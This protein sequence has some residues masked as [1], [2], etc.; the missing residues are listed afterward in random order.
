[1]LSGMGSLPA[2]RLTELRRGVVPY[3]VLSLLASEECYAFD[4]VR[5][6]AELDGL[7]TS[8]GTVYPLLGR[9]ADSGLVS[10]TWRADEGPRPRKYYAL[11]ADGRVA[12]D[13]FRAEWR[14]FERIV[15][16]VL[17]LSQ[18]DR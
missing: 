13:Q 8:E 3:C 5:R 7:V 2:G 9:L 6:L 4:L 15:D 12:L 10:T 17:D 1:M 14:R 11:T 18:E 16:R